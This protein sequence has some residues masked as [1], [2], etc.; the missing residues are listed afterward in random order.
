ME[1]VLTTVLAI[2][3]T[4]EYVLFSYGL[5]DVFKDKSGALLQSNKLYQKAVAAL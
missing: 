5:T 1:L 3:L 4:K 2:I